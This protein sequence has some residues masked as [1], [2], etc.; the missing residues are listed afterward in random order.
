M[1]ITNLKT[2]MLEY[3][4]LFGITLSTILAFAVSIYARIRKSRSYRTPRR[5]ISPIRVVEADE[6][7][8]W[9]WTLKKLINVLIDIDIRVFNSSQTINKVQ[10]NKEQE[11]PTKL[12]IKYYSENPENWSILFKGDKDVIGWSL[13]CALSDKGYSTVLNGNYNELMLK[14]S[15]FAVKID[16]E[17][18]GSYNIYLSG[19]VVGPELYRS[20]GGAMLLTHLFKKFSVFDQYGIKI[21]RLCTVAWTHD[22]VR[23]CRR[24]GF[25]HVGNSNEGLIFEIANCDILDHLRSQIR[26]SKIN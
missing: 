2:I 26:I 13:I 9:G 10:L 14:D 15:N 18:P 8:E 20:Q 22:G 12:W 7:A 4:S 17:V 19:V 3:M 25:K 1:N 11:G 24:L 16:H 21:S 6:F 23:V 5:I